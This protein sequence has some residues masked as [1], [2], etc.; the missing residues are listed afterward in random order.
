STGVMD[1]FHSRS[2]NGGKDFSERRSIG[3]AQNGFTYRPRV[4]ASGDNVH[5]VWSDSFDV[6]YG[7]STNNGLSFDL[8]QL[9]SAGNALR[10]RLAP[11]GSLVSAVWDQGG[12]EPLFNLLP[13]GERDIYL[14][15]T[16]ANRA[17]LVLEGV[18]ALQGPF[19]GNVLAKSKPTLLRVRIQ[20]AFF[21]KLNTKL[22]LVYDTVQNG[23]PTTVTRTE[24][25]TLTAGVNT[26]YLPADDFIL[27]G[28]TQFRASVT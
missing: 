17:D 8:Y 5:V 25:I 13:R 28:G 9:N 2:I 1:V 27:P 24:P 23:V 3:L 10:P 6:Y 26:L 19:A 16:V 4:A 14:G 15:A 21:R 12:S 11:N 18:E 20:N 7:L 22:K